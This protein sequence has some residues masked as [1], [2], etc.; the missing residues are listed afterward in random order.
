MIVSAT[1]EALEALQTQQLFRGANKVDPRA[2]CLG[3]ATDLTPEHRQ[4][5]FEVTRRVG[6]DHPNR[7]NARRPRRARVTQ[8]NLPDS[9]HYAEF[10]HF[11]S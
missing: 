8:R 9:L 3:R 11:I 4:G 10:V 6:D 1:D 5:I 2:G 7:E